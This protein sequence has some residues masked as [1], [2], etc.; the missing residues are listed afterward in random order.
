MSN[1]VAMATSRVVKDTLVA[2]N[3]LYCSDLTSLVKL[4]QICSGVYWCF[5]VPAVPGCSSVPVFP[6]FRT[7]HNETPQHDW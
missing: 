5:G 2:N 7:C 6:G 1:F 3:F 4:I